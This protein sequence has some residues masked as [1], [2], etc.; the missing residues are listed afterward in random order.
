MMMQNIVN[1]PLVSIGM[2][3]YNGAKYIRRAIDSLLGQDYENIEL[4]ISDNASNDGTLD[5]CEDYALIDQRIRIYKHSHNVGGNKNFQ[6]VANHAKGEYFMWAADDD[7]WKPEFISA[8]VNELNLYPEAGVAMCAVDRNNSDGT[9]CDTIQFC[10]KNNPN[11]KSF[12]SMTL[13]LDTPLKYN[14]FIYGIFRTQLIRSAIPIP[15]IVSGDRRFLSQF[16]LGTR[17]RYVD[18]VLHIR[19]VHHKQ[20]QD[21]YPLDDLIKKLIA[22]HINKQWFYFRPIL[23]VSRILFCSK[24]V[25]WHRKSFIPFIFSVMLLKTIKYGVREMVRSFIVRFLPYSLQKRLLRSVR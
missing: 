19:I 22:Y 17:F 24:I 23:V 7:Y 15:V 8:L 13:A 9:L 1:K 21:R 2:P 16:A 6:T 5:I 11:I 14:L 18:S 10:G 25:P 4:I 20:Y 12:L 3:V